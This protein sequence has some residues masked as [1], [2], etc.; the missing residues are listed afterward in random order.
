[1][2]CTRVPAQYHFSHKFN[3]H[4]LAILFLVNDINSTSIITIEKKSKLNIL[5]SLHCCIQHELATMKRKSSSEEEDKN[6]KNSEREQGGPADRKRPHLRPS[7]DS[8]DLGAGYDPED[9]KVVRAINL[10]QT[11]LL[12][13]IEEHSGTF[14]NSNFLDLRGYAYGISANVDHK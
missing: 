1:M 9:R 2:C 5:L 10:Y 11:K 4:S 6:S 7:T 3:L 14:K 13:F 8:R 12:P